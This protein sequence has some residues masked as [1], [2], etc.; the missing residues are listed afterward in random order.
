VLTVAA[1]FALERSSERFAERIERSAAALR[2]DADALDHALS[3]RLPIWRAAWSMIEAHP[4]NGVGVRGFRYAYPEHVDADDRFL[5]E[6]E[7]GEQGA[8]HAHQIVL[9]IL[10]ETGFIGL[11]CWLAALM[12]GLRALRASTAEARARAW[13]ASLALLTL[14][15]PLNTHYAVYSSFLSVLLFALLALWL[16]ALSTRTPPAR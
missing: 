13:P 7:R 3:Y 1:G 12:L 11:L 6:G 10:S 2:G 15:F 5:F 9:E 14:L 4:A 8:Y 16:G